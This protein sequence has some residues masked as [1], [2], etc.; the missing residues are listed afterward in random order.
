MNRIQLNKEL[1]QLREE[2]EK[3]QR[4]VDNIQGCMNELMRKRNE[5]DMEQEERSGQMLFDQMFGG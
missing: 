4:E 3:A 1:T 2:R 5:L